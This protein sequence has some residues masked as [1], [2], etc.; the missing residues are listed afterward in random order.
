[1]MK[2]LETNE[3][4]KASAKKLNTLSHPINKRCKEEPNGN[5]RTENYS[6]QNKSS[7][8]GSTVEWRKQGKGKT[9][10]ITQYE[11]QR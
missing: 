5:F 8:M 4:Q 3:K 10:E 9:I 11:Q 2:M 7:V 6:N 1:M